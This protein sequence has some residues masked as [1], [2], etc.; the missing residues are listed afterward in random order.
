VR[1]RPLPASLLL[2]LVWGLWHLPLLHV[3]GESDEGLPLVGFLVLITGTSV[4]MS[5]LVSAARGSVLVAAVVNAALDAS[6]SFTGV[7]GGDHVTFWAAVAVTT[8]LALLVVRVTTT[9]P[10]SP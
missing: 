8:L 6:Y 4:L 3:P 2:G 10:S 5:A 1:L 7:V 9:Y